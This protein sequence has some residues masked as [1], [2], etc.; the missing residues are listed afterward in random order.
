MDERIEALLRFWFG[1]EPR[2]REELEQRT[3]LWFE[4]DEALDAEIE[5]RFGEMARLAASGALDHYSATPKGRLA[6]IVLFDQFPRN[7][8][9]GTA[10]AFAQDAKALALTTQGIDTG[11]D[12]QL[13]VLERCVFYMPLQH[14]EDEQAQA[15]SVR[16]F[17]Q[18]SADESAPDFYAPMLQS[19]LEYAHLHRDI[20]TRFGRFPHRNRALGRPDTEAER[21]YLRDGAPR[22]G[23]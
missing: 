20:V 1:P 6:L 17:E 9:R 11:M 12:R 5:A 8:H 2:T 15:L 10:A 16:M 18:L 21:E 13:T 4:A 22:F 23:Q 7:L 14:A 3:R 19:M